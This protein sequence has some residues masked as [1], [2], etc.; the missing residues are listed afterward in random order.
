MCAKKSRGMHVGYKKY[1]ED[2]F[3]SGKLLIAVNY[4]RK[5]FF[6]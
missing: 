2:L 5:F 6:I 1:L 4:E 3:N